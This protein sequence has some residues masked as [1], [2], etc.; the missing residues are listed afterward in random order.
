VP[1]LLSVV[2][3]GIGLYVRLRVLESP[4]LAKPRPSGPW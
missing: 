4:E 1:F 2:L 3:I